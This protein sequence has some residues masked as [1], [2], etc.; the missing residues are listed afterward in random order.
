[1]DQDNEPFKLDQTY[2]EYDVFSLFK[3]NVTNLIQIKAALAKNF[4]I[5]PSEIENMP[6]WE[7]E[8]FIGEMNDQVQEEKN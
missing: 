2:F 8:L 6:M 3:I 5:Q 4:H 7:Y 1:M